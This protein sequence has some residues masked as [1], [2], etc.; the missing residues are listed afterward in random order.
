MPIPAR[1]TLR[2]AWRSEADL[3][4]LALCRE[5]LSLAGIAFADAD[6][7]ETPSAIKMHG[8]EIE[9]ARAAGAPLLRELGDAALRADWPRSLPPIVTRY[10]VDGPHW[11]GI[12]MGIH[13]ANMVWVNRALA[14]K[15]GVP[16]PTDVA[17]LLAWLRHAQRHVEAPLAVGAEPW[18]V[19][20]LFEAVV[21]GSAGASLYEQ[22][23]IELRPS[24]WREPP[25]LL[26]LGNFLSLRS[27]ADDGRMQQD[28]AAQ[29]AAVRDGRAALQVMGDW[30]RTCAGEELIEWVV[31]G[32]AAWFVAIIDYFVPLAQGSGAVAERAALALTEPAFQARFASRKGC[33]PATGP[34]LPADGASFVPSF[35]FDQCCAVQTRRALQSVVADHFIRG[36]DASTL[37]RALTEAMS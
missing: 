6:P 24:V 20:V 15:I 8:M 31:P 3:A 32:T 18:Q 21:L 13:R 2:H 37:A 5:Q 25:M 26:A 22:A 14:A 10:M 36:S 4:A 11:H 23:F 17:G 35:T 30:A 16:T 9:D 33:L 29:L 19:G 7:G 1:W 12:P 34:C 28:W 27:F